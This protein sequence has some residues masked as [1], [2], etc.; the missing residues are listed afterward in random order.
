MLAACTKW[1]I[2]QPLPSAHVRATPLSFGMYVTPDPEQNPIDPPERFSG[3]HAAL[4]FEVSSGEV[5][6]DVPVYAI[7]PGKV[8]FSGY[9]NGYGGTVVHRCRIGKEDVT[10][11]YGHLDLK[12]LPKEGV[13]VRS[14]DTLGLLGAHRSYASGYNRKHL[15]LGIHKGRQLVMAGYVQDEQTLES[16][17][18]PKSVLPNIGIDL[19]TDQ[20]GEVPYWQEE[21]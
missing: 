13:R 12:G 17:I 16:Y 8:I 9:V 18:D 4:D 10:V 5:E 2:H 19:L 11:L 1:T 6:G 7:C 15:H 14:G 21:E 20:P 3:Y